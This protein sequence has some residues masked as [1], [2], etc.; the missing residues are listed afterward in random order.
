MEDKTMKIQPVWNNR[1]LVGY[2]KSEK[3]AE[4]LI[5]SKLQTV[6]KGWKITAKT[7]DSFM[8]EFCGLSAGFV[9]SI[10]P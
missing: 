9:Y 7:R 3:S 2:A 10:H 8:V 4:K 6:P 5:R 1:E